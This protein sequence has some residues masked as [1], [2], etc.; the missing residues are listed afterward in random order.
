MEF[1]LLIS[2]TSLI[3][4]TTLAVYVYR[5]HRRLNILIHAV[6]GK[7]VVKVLSALRMSKKRRKRYMVFEVISD[8]EINS[9]LL[10]YEVRAAFRKLFGE[11][12]LAR[13]AIAIQYFNSKTNMGV[14][15]YSHLYKYK[16]LTS[17]GVVRKVG[18]VKVNIIPLKTT[19]TLRKA[20]KYVKAKESFIKE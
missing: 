12:H 11:L 4:V 15:K 7:S 2:L 6:R 1:E 17:L 19:G 8:K 5:I 13:A 18:D 16:L 9:G 3:L 14:I 10:D 20:L